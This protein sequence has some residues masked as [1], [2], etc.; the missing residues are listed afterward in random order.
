[1]G[2]LIIGGVLITWALILTISDFRTRTLPNVLTLP[3]LL[4]AAGWA[5][6]ST[7]WWA[8]VGGLCW[9]LLYVAVGHLSAGIGGGDIK[10]APTLGLLIGT[11]GLVPVL[12]AIG[13]A[14]IF[15]IATGLF[16]KQKRIPHG[17]SMLLATALVWLAVPAA[18]LF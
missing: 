17:P 13:L 2:E 14:Q 5:I 10:L 6:A 4:V 16:L 11:N 12:I 18:R 1:M 3:A 9:F 7:N 15:S 8:V